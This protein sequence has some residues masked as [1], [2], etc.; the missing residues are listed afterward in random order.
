MV[1]GTAKGTGRLPLEEKILAEQLRP[2]AE[3]REYIAE[4]ARR[5]LDAIKKSG[6]AEGMVVGSIA[7]NTWVKGDR[8]L[9]VFLLFPPDMPREALET[10]GLALARSIARMFTKTFCEKYAEHPYINATI[11]S[12]DVDLVPC[13]NVASAAKIQSAVDRT[14]FHTR[15]IT[16]RING[17][18][19]DVLLLKQFAKAGGIYGSDQMTEGFSGYLC[20]LLILRYGGFGEL[21]DAAA[22]W[23]PPT[24]ID[25]GEHAAKEFTEPLVVIDPVDP[26]RNV[27]AAVSLDR[28]AEF[29][30][31][32]RG[33]REA[34]SEA[35]FVLAREHPCCPDNLSALL[36][37]RGTSLYAVT[38]ATPPFIEEIVVP[39]L[40][41]STL[42]IS[43]LLTRSGFIV[44]HAHYRMGTHRCML[45]F[46][47]LVDELP[48][49]RRHEGP[50]VWNQVNAEKFREKYRASP[51]P[52]PFIE[53]GR[54]VTEV[55]R[56][57][58]RASDLLTSPA[59]LNVGVGRHVR[60]S[61]AKDWCVLEGADCWQEEFS[62]FIAGFF[63][64]RSPLV[65][66]E[67]GRAGRT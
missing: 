49:I 5:L 44:H 2:S 48:P 19:D 60:E 43:D 54:Y 20:E 51:L 22:E 40:K 7:R 57:F 8:D 26:R 29:V 9:D 38:F 61:L 42:A 32:A 30:E 41:R 52:G 12:I 17:L 64:R 3:E 47:L 25:I 34:P 35:F 31:L 58:I 4:V 37:S 27:A 24:I 45:L 16:D 10:E 63:A 28:M 66:I 53:N 46:E 65:R 15:F 36:A 1:S 62:A 33:Y 13:Y 50:P 14:P 23:R 59:L 11:D 21:L 56:E 39:Q 6:K 18:V 67:R 55:P